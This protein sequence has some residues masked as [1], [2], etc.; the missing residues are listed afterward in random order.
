[1]ERHHQSLI[2]EQSLLRTY[3]IVSGTVLMT[4]VNTYVLVKREIY[5]RDQRH[6]PYALRACISARTRP[7]AALRRRLT[8]YSGACHAGDG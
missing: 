8:D 1:M 5:Q 3:L 2:A 6:W 7:A 4:T